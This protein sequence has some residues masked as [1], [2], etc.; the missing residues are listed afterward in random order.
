MESNYDKMKNQARQLFLN[1]DQ[2]EMIE[3][4]HLEHTD[5]VIWIRFL[6]E[7]YEIDRK[8]GVITRS[9]MSRPGKTASGTD[10]G[11]IGTDDGGDK[12]LD[13]CSAVKN[14]NNVRGRESTAG[15]ASFEVSM[16][17][18]DMLCHS[19]ERPVLSGEWVTIHSLYGVKGS[20]GHVGL[21]EKYAKLIDGKTDR[22]LE[23]CAAMGGKKSSGKEDA[24]SILPVFDFFPIY[25]QFWE[26]DEDFPAQLQ[27][28]LDGNAANFVY[29]ETMW[30]MI[31]H[32]CDRIE[33]GIKNAADCD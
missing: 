10:A 2:N 18:Y 11:I 24:G 1:Y 20:K 29:Y 31:M 5:Q 6:G 27:I 3:K 16:S 33:Q 12:N 17:I 13:E 28:L 23:I 26:S 8:S 32:I 30:Y 9:K 4:F 19:K 14:R 15:G 7:L 25:L 22:M 21:L